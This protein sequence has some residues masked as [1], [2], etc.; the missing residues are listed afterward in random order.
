MLAFF[1][2]KQ[3]FAKIYTFNVTEW[4]IYYDDL[5]GTIFDLLKN[6]FKSIKIVQIVA[7]QIQLKSLY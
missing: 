1:A 3:Y 7:I 6:E 4:P 5:L 2:S